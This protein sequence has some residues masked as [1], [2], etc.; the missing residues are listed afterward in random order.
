MMIKGSSPSLSS[1]MNGEMTPGQ[2]GGGQRAEQSQAVSTVGF[3][4]LISGRG[5]FPIRL[6]KQVRKYC[7]EV[8][9]GFAANRDA[10]VL[11]VIPVVREGST[12]HI[13]ES[14]KLHLQ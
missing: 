7:H 1:D 8:Q 13:P 10:D 6:S 9:V 2:G 4:D 11:M 12:V 3:D 14:P 5:I